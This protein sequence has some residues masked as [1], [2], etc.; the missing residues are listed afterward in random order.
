MPNKFHNRLTLSDIH[1][2]HA[3]EYA[4]AIAREG[5]T[6]FTSADVGKVAL[7]QND[8]SFWVLVNEVGP[9]WK[10]FAAAGGYDPLALRAQN[11]GILSGGVISTASST[12]IDITAGSGIVIDYTDPTAPVLSEV[13]WEDQFGVTIDN[14]GDDNSTVI[15]FDANGDLQQTI[16]T[17]FDSA[18][19]RDQIGI[20]TVLHVGSV[21][22][23]TFTAPENLGYG[24][25][26]TPEDFVREVIGPCNVSGNVF[27]PN[28]A[29]LNVDN[30]GGD[31]FDIGSNFRIDPEL[32]NQRTQPAATPA[33][34]LRVYRQ[35]DPTLGMIPEVPPTDLINPTQYDNGSGTLQSVSAN[36]WTI[37]RIF[38]D[39]NGLVL[40]A[41]G[42]EV[43][44]KLTDAESALGTES[45]Q[46][47][48]PLPWCVFRCFMI[49]KGSATD[50]SDDGQAKFFAATAFRIAGAGGASVN[51]S[52][53]TLPG[54]ADTEVQFNDGGLFG[55]D[56]GFTYLAGTVTLAG[57]IVLDG[58]VNEVALAAD[59]D[60]NVF[61][62]SPKPDVSGIGAQNTALGREVLASIQADADKNVAIG[63]YAG[64]KLTT[65][66]T[67]V[68]VGAYAGRNVTSGSQNAIF[69]HSA[70]AALTTGWGNVL[71]GHTAADG[72]TTG[73]K[74]VVFG[75]ASGRGITTGNTNLL[76][77]DNVA[78]ILVGGTGNLVFG[79]DQEV[80]SAGTN[81]FLNIAG[82]LYGDIG[83][84]YLVIG[85]SLV[86]PVGP[87]RLRVE[88]DVVFLGTLELTLPAASGYDINITKDD[89]TNPLWG[90]LYNSSSDGV[91]LFQVGASGGGVLSLIANSSASDYLGIPAGVGG[92]A[93][94]YGSLTFATGTGG[95][96]TEAMRINS[97]QTVSFLD[98][99]GITGSLTI[100]VDL[101]I[102]GMVIAHDPSDEKLIITPA[103]RRTRFGGYSIAIGDLVASTAGDPDCVENTIIGMNS[104]HKLVSSTHNVC[105]GDSQTGRMEFGTDYNV[106]IGSQACESMYL[107]SRHNVI[108]GAMAASD[109]QNYDSNVLIGSMVARNANS[110][111]RNVIIGEDANRNSNNSEETVILGYRCAQ[112][113]T[114]ADRCIYI[115]ANLNPVATGIDLLD[116][117]GFIK[118]DMTSDACLIGTTT[119]ESDSTNLALG[120]GM[121]SS[122]AGPGS[123]NIF[124][125]HGST[126]AIVEGDGNFVLGDGGL[127]L[128]G[129]AGEH[130]DNIIIGRTAG[131][132]T[133]IMDD[134]ILIGVG[135]NP[136]T[137]SN[138]NGIN[139]G[140][141]I[142]GVGGVGGPDRVRIGGGGA[143]TADA[144]LEV[145]G[146]DG[147][148][149]IPRLT[150]T[151]RNN[152]T[153]SDGMII[154]NTSTNLF[155]GRQSGA[156]VRLSP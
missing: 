45:F 32:P 119:I 81:Y 54:G 4:D 28:G 72:M 78:N 12:T 143:L 152:L 66:D 8:T 2:I 122:W 98:H 15:A 123:G 90:R 103:D 23:D 22:I 74:N 52:G 94:T 19:R 89:G 115:G 69:G 140:G 153:P 51:I 124:V 27:G 99:V 41:Y 126:L 86:K 117:G 18:K 93:N 31:V 6:G 133:A 108:I 63:Y 46:E 5:A 113:I 83:S 131:S 75:R 13:T 95:S 60:N 137:G 156:W 101:E 79:V 110:M 55:G 62:G 144:A 91:A 42:Q 118:A 56:S 24:G 129:N 38:I 47:K 148:L 109:S 139:I 84:K 53:I 142:W 67:D 146:T 10:G 82:L 80:P 49:V 30:S 87:E 7:Q 65:A 29:N 134:C 57:D 102:N 11:T 125:G 64:N 147:A 151:Q 20:G 33:T 26:T 17:L 120:D 104:W 61:V 35:P 58:T 59:D 25:T 141:V 50:L 112:D 121:P 92:L 145:A 34:F 1:V 85:G 16:L 9:T 37:Q 76:L 155:Q 132:S 77:G 150:T 3:Y 73:A 100:S 44:N 43:F 48:S 88:G 39:P 105:I 111:L 116:I 36:N 107:Q 114:A 21:I 68:M 97:D 154:Y 40:V 128:S 138:T 135:A 127:G 14:I 106:I 130:Y 136:P 96:A 149:L 71:V 70:G